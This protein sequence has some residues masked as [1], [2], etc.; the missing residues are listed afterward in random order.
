MIVWCWELK[1]NGFFKSCAPSTLYP[2]I[3]IFPHTTF[4]YVYQSSS[5]Y[6][7]VGN[8][9]NTIRLLYFK[10]W[11]FTSFLQ[12]TSLQ[13]IKEKLLQ[14]C[15]HVYMC[16]H[17]VEKLDKIQFLNQSR[18]H[19]IDIIAYHCILQWETENCG[20]GRRHWSN[21]EVYLMLYK[22]NSLYL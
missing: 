12:I 10:F 22:A 8:Y 4:L 13:V 17:A 5:N 2:P 1:K 14:F 6:R 9:I 19:F 20:I 16:I 7:V 11:L 15:F 21:T 18:L 3:L